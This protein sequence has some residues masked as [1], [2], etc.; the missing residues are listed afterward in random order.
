MEKVLRTV[1]FAWVRR[2]L[3]GYD[4]KTTKNYP[5]NTYV[6]RART[7]KVISWRAS[8]L[9]FQS[10]YI[11][12]DVVASQ[13]VGDVRA[14]LLRVIAPKGSHGEMISENFV[15]LFYNDVLVKSFN[16]IE[17]VLRGDTGRPI[18]FLG[19]VVEVT[20][21]FRKKVTADSFYMVLPSNASLQTFPDNRP[22]LYRIRLPEMMHLQGLWKVGLMN[23][24]FPTTLAPPPSNIDPLAIMVSLGNTDT[25][26]GPFNMTV[27][28]IE[29]VGDLVFAT[30]LALEKN[31]AEHGLNLSDHITILLFPRRTLSKIE[32]RT[33][34]GSTLG[35]SAYLGQSWAFR[36]TTAASQWT[37]MTLW[38]IGTTMC[39]FCKRAL[40]F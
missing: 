1:C 21:H 29:T 40:F 6:I 11:Y 5:S 8:H 23:L 7:D 16:T 14:N 26:Y 9:A 22:V 3:G 28:I 25:T 30:H 31:A 35:F 19:G 39:S 18:P 36:Q 34:R 4:K 10:I 13:V 12:S 17:I 33:F 38:S 20:L 32:I 27:T 2:V 37:I 24:I 15:H